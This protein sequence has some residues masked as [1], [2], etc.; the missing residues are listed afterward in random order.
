MILLS[1]KELIVFIPPARFRGKTPHQRENEKT[2]LMSGV[3]FG[4]TILVTIF[5]IRHFCRESR[6][7]KRETRNARRET[8]LPP[9]QR[10]IELPPPQGGIALCNFR[11]KPHLFRRDSILPNC[12]NNILW[13]N[14]NATTKYCGFKFFLTDADRIHGK[15]EK[16]KNKKFSA[17]KPRNLC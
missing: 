5:V 11:A 1:F 12:P 7:A 14:G 15:R 17:C 16:T 6:D 8:R 9:H 2:P 10:G 3:I 13:P 4:V